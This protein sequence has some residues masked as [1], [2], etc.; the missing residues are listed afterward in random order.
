MITHPDHLLTH[1]HEL[2]VEFRVD[3]LGLLQFKDLLVA[4]LGQMLLTVLE[5]LNHLHPQNQAHYTE[6]LTE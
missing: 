5:T 4:A 1:S 3:H 6:T 2:K